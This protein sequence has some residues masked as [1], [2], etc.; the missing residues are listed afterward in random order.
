MDTILLL[1]SA[2]AGMATAA[3]Y[4]ALLKKTVRQLTSKTNP[5]VL[6]AGYFLRLAVCVA[7]FVAVAWGNHIDRIAACLAGFTLIQ[8][9]SIIKAGKQPGFIKGGSTHGN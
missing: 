2:A 4:M 1:A 3:V 5:A 6:V 9:I 7:C 8:V